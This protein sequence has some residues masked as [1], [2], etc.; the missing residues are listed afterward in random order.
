MSRRA[1]RLCALACIV[2][3]VAASVIQGRGV[4]DFGDGSFMF[5]LAVGFGIGALIRLHRECTTEKKK[6]REPNDND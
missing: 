2:V 6:R 3:G 5:P 1:S 4:F